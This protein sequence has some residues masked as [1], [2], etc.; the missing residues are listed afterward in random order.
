M[1]PQTNQRAELTA[2]LKGVELAESQLRQ[3]NGITKIQIWS[4]SQY[5]INCASVWGL[6]WKKNGWKKQGG[7]IQHL[8][9]I[10]TLVEKTIQLGFTLEYKWLKGHKGGESQY[11]FP[12][13]FNHQVD[14]L[15]T[16]A[17]R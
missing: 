8:D 16:S 5:S 11:A 15:A 13:M 6:T 9:I 7:P 4:D 17:L 3:Q 10:R 12:W 14:S 1:E 2:L